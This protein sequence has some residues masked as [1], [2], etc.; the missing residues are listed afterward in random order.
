MKRML[1]HSLTSSFIFSGVSTDERIG[2]EA[3]LEYIEE[4][5][6][7]I[8]EKT[9]SRSELKHFFDNIELDI[10]TVQSLPDANKGVSAWL[11]HSSWTAE[12]DPAELRQS[13]PIEIAST[14]NLPIPELGSRPETFLQWLLGQGT[15]LSRCLDWF[16]TATAFSSVVASL[17]SADALLANIE[18]GLIRFRF[19][20]N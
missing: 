7:S 8:N 16:Y 12:I 5:V 3:R 13:I 18:A 11:V 2:L 14:I 6:K 17:I 9:N 1:P 20:I 10:A 19:S 15:A 4:I